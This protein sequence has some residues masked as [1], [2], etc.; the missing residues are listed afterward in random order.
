MSIS[1]AISPGELIDRCSILEIKLARIEDASKLRN[2]RHEHAITAQL[3]KQ[4]VPPSDRILALAAA[5]KAVNDELWQIEDKIREF[6]R[7]GDFGPGFVAVAR[8]V[9]RQN[10]KR[11]ALKRE[12]NDLLGSAIVEEKSYSPY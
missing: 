5:L 9:Y 8:S 3:V 11:A 7:N 4:C 6:E 2:V 12:I 10:D 1:I